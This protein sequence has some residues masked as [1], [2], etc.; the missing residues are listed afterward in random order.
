MVRTTIRLLLLGFAV[1]GIIALVGT[2]DELGLIL[3]IL[4]IGGFVILGLA[5]LVDRWR[6]GS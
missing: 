1:A 5:S 6:S 4:G 2:A 3:F